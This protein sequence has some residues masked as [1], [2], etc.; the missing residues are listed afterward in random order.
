MRINELFSAVGK[1]DLH[2][3]TKAD[4]YNTIR[5]ILKNRKSMGFRNSIE[6]LYVNTSVVETFFDGKIDKISMHLDEIFDMTCVQDYL[7]FKGLYAGQDMDDPVKITASIQFSWVLSITMF[8]S[9]VNMLLTVNQLRLSHL[10]EN[11][12]CV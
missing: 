3:S 12:M 7:R 2:A 4:M 9:V 11:K 1:S 8:A 10:N 6:D 5:E